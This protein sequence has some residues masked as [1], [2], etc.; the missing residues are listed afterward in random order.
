MTQLV[1]YSAWQRME[2]VRFLS[3]LEKVIRI[4]QWLVVMATMALCFTRRKQYMG[5]LAKN[6]YCVQ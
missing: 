6:H 4:L 2:Q 3:L 5:A 1:Q